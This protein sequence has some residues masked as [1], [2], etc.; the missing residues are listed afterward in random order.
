MNQ[1]IISLT[2]HESQAQQKGTFCGSHPQGFIPWMHPTALQDQTLAASNNHKKLADSSD[3][4][5][6]AITVSERKISQL[7]VK[8][9]QK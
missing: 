3:P 1:L 6:M 2:G 4:S 7:K 9:K 5:E 8:F